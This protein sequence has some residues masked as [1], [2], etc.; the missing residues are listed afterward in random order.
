MAQGQSRA[1]F[2]A[3]GG[4][5]STSP[6][7]G[8]MRRAQNNAVIETQRR[9]DAMSEA[10]LAALVNE[11]NEV[12]CNRTAPLKPWETGA[13]ALHGADPQLRMAQ[14]LSNAWFILQCTVIYVRE[15]H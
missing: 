6:A 15:K 9:I 8:D 2:L 5:W 11:M 12:C 1:A 4:L 10:E 3:A 7:A 14:T 13:G